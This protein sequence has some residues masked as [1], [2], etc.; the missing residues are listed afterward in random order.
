[1]VL[2]LAPTRNFHHLYQGHSF[3]KLQQRQQQQQQHHASAQTTI[4]RG[5]TRRK[6]VNFDNKVKVYMIPTRQEL[7]S[8]SNDCY[9]SKSDQQEIKQKIRACLQ[10]RMMGDNSSSIHPNTNDDKNNNSTSNDDDDDECWRGLENFAPQASKARRRR[11][12]ATLDLILKDND[13]DKESEMRYSCDEDGLPKV[14]RLLTEYSARRAYLRGLL[15]QQEK[16]VEGGSPVP[17]QVMT[18]W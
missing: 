3:S 1:M 8:T 9:W 5:T 17:I 18:R 15:D 10:R 14:Y 2:L 6:I 16:G 12:R 11:I 13:N 7:A 4:K